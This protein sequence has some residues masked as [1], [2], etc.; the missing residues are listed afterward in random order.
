MANM[1]VTTGA[2]FIPEI[3]SDEV[4]ATY[5]ANLVAA[6]LVRNLNH[7]GK[8]G[9]TINIPTPGR[10]AASAKVADT[11]VT[12]ITDTATNTQVV[13]NKHFEWSTQ[14]EDIAELQALSSMRK[15]YTDDAGYA[16]AKNVDSQIITDLDGASA[17][18]GGNAVI[19][20]VTDW[21][22]SILA[23]IEVLNDADIPVD[24]RSL[25]VTPSCM[26]ALLGEE[27]FTEQ[28]FIGDGKAIKT[29]KIGSIYGVDVYMSTQVGTGSTEKAFLF[30][31]DA[32][33]L[34]TQ[35][36]VRAQTQYKQEYLADLFTADT[37]YGTKVIRPGSIQELTS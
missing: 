25:V 17:L 35:Q 2:V 23:A 14:I 13:I 11:A 18:T 24:G 7:Q 12:Y 27:R 15:F 28:Q 30:Q 29:G 5:K 4:I 31:K 36:A 3:W 37:V 34:A 9:D 32:H 21:D 16:L 33:V 1:T 19:T 26:T 6:N 8:K 22:A 20:S 10:N